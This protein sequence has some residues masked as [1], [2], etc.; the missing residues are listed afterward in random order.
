MTDRTLLAAALTF[1]VTTAFATAVS[2]SEPHLQDQPLGVRFPPRG[3]TELHLAFG[4]G[5]GVAA[6]WPMPV[7]ATVAALRAQPGVSWP[8]RTCAALGVGVI[9][10]TLIEPAT[11][12]RWPRSPAAKATVPLNLLSGMA[13]LLAATRGQR[14]G[15]A[16]T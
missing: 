6:P 7:I 9:V 11:W 5:S 4:L 3:S 2:V 10:G 1:T 12:G 16:P 8:A 13:L 15:G 14:H